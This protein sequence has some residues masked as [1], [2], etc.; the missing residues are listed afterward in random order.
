MDGSEKRGFSLLS[1]PCKSL[2]K[3]EIHRFWAVAGQTITAPL[4]SASLYFFIFGVSLG[5]K[6]SMHPTV[7]YLAFIIPGL[8]IMAVLNNSYQ[9][10][11]SSIVNAKYHGNIK[12]VLI[13]PLHYGEIV[14]AYVLAAVVRGL[15][16]GFLVF[17]LSC[18]FR[19]PVDMNP[20]LAVLVAVIGSVTFAL[21]GMIA[22]ICSDGWEALS[23]WS[24]FVLLPLTYLGGVF[25]SIDILPPFWRSLSCMNPLL[26]IVDV[27]RYAFLGISDINPVTDII[28]VLS[29]TTILFVICVK[30]LKSGYGLRS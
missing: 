20:F 30:L 5:S 8:I 27:F 4:I 3:K 24:Q 7:P 28:V 17:L 13:A 1:I 23:V 9:N 26:Y 19:L 16:V 10:T 18:A 11:S 29:M 14:T 15:T 6:I 12:D 21:L 25:Y 22:G 2:L